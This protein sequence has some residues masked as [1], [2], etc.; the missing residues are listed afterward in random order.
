MLNINRISFT[1]CSLLASV[2]L[3][4]NATQ[5][6]A[7]NR[8]PYPSNYDLK[9]EGASSYESRGDHSESPYFKHQDY[10]NL[11]SSGGLTI[12]NKFKTY[13]Q[14][15][16]YTCG[17]A[18]ALMVINHFESVIGKSSL[19]ELAIAKKMKTSPD[20]GTNTRQMVDFFINL[21][22]NVES[23]LTHKNDK[24]GRSFD[25]SSKFQAFV[26][27]RLKR[28]Q[29][30]MVNWIDWAGHWQVIIGYDTLGTKGVGDDVLILADPYDT[31]D[32]LQDG[33]YAVNMERFFE[34]WFGGDIAPK[35]QKVQQWLIATPKNLATQ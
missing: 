5:V 1:L 33:Y 7:D 2:T 4:Q 11:R 16:E 17:P 9:S 26:L 24:K 34:M 18:A 13:Q 14:S 6:T 3:A 10:F 8:I 19:Q 31:S 27:D 21:D 20:V 29:P 28:N 22:W 25:D 23:S 15:K 32:H 35:G 30:I 12:L